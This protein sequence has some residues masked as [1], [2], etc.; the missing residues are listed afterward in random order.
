MKMK[1]RDFFKT[2]GVTACGAV[3]CVLGLSKTKKRGVTEPVQKQ[4]QQM[5]TNFFPEKIISSTVFHGRFF[6]CTC[7]SLWEIEEGPYGNLQRKLITYT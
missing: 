2:L 7:H 6:I 3:A 5:V 4:K 1:R